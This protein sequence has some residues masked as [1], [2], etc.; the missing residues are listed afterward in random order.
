M[1]LGLQDA[2][3]LAAVLT[4][5]SLAGEHLGDE[6][7]LG[8]YA[9]ERKGENLTMLLACDALDTLFRLP[10]WATGVRKLGMTAVDR[11]LPAKRLLMRRALGLAT[12]RNREQFAALRGHRH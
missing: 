7:V 5:A 3:A 8:R 10:N 9:R 2:V 11:T 6:R 12:E 1:N 4:T